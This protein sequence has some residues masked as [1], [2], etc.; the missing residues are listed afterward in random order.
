M[1]KYFQ[2]VWMFTRNQTSKRASL[3][4]VRT[5]NLKVKGFMDHGR[6]AYWKQF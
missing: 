4:I 3:R 2:S 1:E 5:N 6:G